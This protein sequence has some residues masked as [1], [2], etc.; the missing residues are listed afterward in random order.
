VSDVVERRK[1]TSA[2][3]DHVWRPVAV[4]VGEPETAPWT[5]L[6]GDDDRATF[7]AGTTD[8]EL[9][10]TET[11]NYRSNLASGSPS[12]WVVLRPT[13]IEPPFEIVTVTADPSEGEA[14][15][16]PGADLV[17][18]VPMLEAIHAW[19]DAFIAEHHV[20][21]PFYKRQRDRADPNALGRRGRIDKER[22]R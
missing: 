5:R 22:D 2:W 9:H 3:I 20:E 10:R 16:E 8:L 7:F 18:P 14:L 11:T 1:A 21:R 12:L 17:E 15:T 4:L 13:G 19:V 6:E